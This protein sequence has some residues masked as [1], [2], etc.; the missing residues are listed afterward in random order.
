MA[1]LYYKKD[2]ILSLDLMRGIIVLTMIVINCAGER[3][4]AY[5]QFTH[6]KWHGCH[7]ADLV[8]PAFLFMVGISTVLSLEKYK[9]TPVLF[10]KRVI[11]RVFILFSVGIY[12]ES[13]MIFNW[14]TFRIPGTLQRIAIVYFCC[15][16]MLFYSKPLHWWITALF[17][18]I[19][20]YLFV[21]LAYLTDKNGT[22]IQGVEQNKNLINYLDNLILGN[23][24]HIQGQNDPDGIIPTFGA[25]INGISGMIA[26]LFI[27][28]RKTFPLITT[29]I[30]LIAFGFL[31]SFHQPLNK[32]L[33]TGSF[34]IFSTGFPLFIIGL[35][36]QFEHIWAYLKGAELIR[37][38]GE[39][40]FAI[41]I[42]Q[43]LF[44][45]LTFYHH[46]DKVHYRL[47]VAK[48]FNAL[49]LSEANSSLMVSLLAIIMFTAIAYLLKKKRWTLK[50]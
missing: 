18:L 34:A 11:P 23:H 37:S 4:W 16:I 10:W 5:T 19:S 50:V 28:R 13:F 8:F 12:L 22:I 40:A 44:R 31:I 33:W 6:A 26:C 47:W 43:D 7:I 21:E 2:R 9:H 32:S 15:A 46:I 36:L 25:L 24:V 30:I 29:G 17:I 42:L 45:R 3:S 20:Y 49:G 41:Y 27:K 35:L 48:Q 39:N 1:S 38:I 14:D